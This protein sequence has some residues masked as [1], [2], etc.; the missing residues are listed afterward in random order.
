MKMYET[1]EFRADALRFLS[2]LDEEPDAMFR[3]LKAD[4]AARSV[5]GAEGFAQQ[6]VDLY[7][8]GDELGVLAARIV[9][10]FGEV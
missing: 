1:P 5:D 10:R 4:A 8:D 9:A 3:W 2:E 6:C 7:G